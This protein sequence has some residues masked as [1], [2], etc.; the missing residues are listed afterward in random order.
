MVNL[1]EYPL[2]KCYTYIK[3]KTACP[4]CNN[5]DNT[6]IGIVNSLTDVMSEEFEDMSCS[7]CNKQYKIKINLQL[8]K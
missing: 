1:N 4:Y 8:I 3:A 7:V 6:E 2:A 5:V